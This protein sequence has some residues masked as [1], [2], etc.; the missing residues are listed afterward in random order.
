MAAS[1]KKSTSC[2]RLIQVQ[3]YIDDLLSEHERGAF[4]RH[5]SGCSICQK[6]L[7][8][9]TEVRKAI[10]TMVDEPMARLDKH[11]LFARVNSENLSRNKSLFPWKVA[12]GLTFAVLLMFTWMVF[13]GKTSLV[14]QEKAKIDAS[15]SVPSSYNPTLSQS[16]LVESAWVTYLTG[17]VQGPL[18]QR[19][20]LFMP[21]GRQLH[22]G[23]GSQVVVQL[24]DKTSVA[25]MENSL[26]RFSWNNRWELELERGSVAVHLDKPR[27]AGFEVECSAGSVGAIGTEFSVQRL[28]D[29]RCSVNLAQGRLRLS[30]KV[31]QRFELEA[32]I[33]R[34]LNKE[35]GMQLDKS[36]LD[37]SLALALVRLFT[38]GSKSSLGQV[39]IESV[40]SG[41]KVY[42]DG[43][44]IGRTPVL[45]A[46]PAK[47]I[48]LSLKADGFLR[49]SVQVFPRPGEK[50]ERHVTLD[51]AAPPL[52]GEVDPVAKAR[53]LL[54]KRKLSLAM[55]VIERHLTKNPDD[56]R[57]LMLLAD[58]YR[59]SSK[60]EKSLDTY[61]RV[62]ALSDDD[63]LCETAMYHAG[64][65]RL[66]ELNRPLQALVTFRSI[67]KQF[68]K[69]LLRQEVAF[70]IAECYLSLK[71][72]DRA[73]RAL[74]DYLRLYPAGTR[75]DDAE[76]LL[77][78]LEDAGWK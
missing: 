47:L 59:M 31:G 29:N 43:M 6:E 68:P 52:Y 1:E 60:L 67:S 18:T 5:L 10:R 28:G 33:I 34:V 58:A 13:K 70:H 49:K 15:D 40:P 73:V 53:E 24:D 77:K 74:T 50:V 2:S 56:P 4:S 75:V 3:S 46:Q 41:A 51:P 39:R 22:V 35:S 9:I 54:A 27:H 38:P 57:T 42:M 76:D 63:N 37:G 17:E 20:E 30:N 78:K 62:A 44:E 12:T 8:S 66:N 25:V 21:L 45:F 36:V 11:A 16:P 71:D 48:S 69:G 64:M 32:P 26:V 7:D 72:Y 61:L 55:S 14:Q 23:A 19:S 65:L